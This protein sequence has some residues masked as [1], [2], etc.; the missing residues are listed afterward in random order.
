[1]GRKRKRYG[2][3]EEGSKRDEVYAMS[4]EDPGAVRGKADIDV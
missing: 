2:G 1:M 3:Q 4:M